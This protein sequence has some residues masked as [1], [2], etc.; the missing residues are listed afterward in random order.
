MK[1]AN[2]NSDSHPVTGR[3]GVAD[4]IKINIYGFAINTLWTPMSTILLPVLVLSF[5]DESVK[6]TQLALITLVGLVLAIIVQPVAGLV[7]DR[8]GCTWGKRRPYILVG[9]LFMIALLMSLGW[10]SSF[11]MLFLVICLLQIASNVANGPWFGFIPDLVPEDKRGI[12]SGVKGVIE[13]LGAIIGIQ[14]IGYLMSQRFPAGEETRLSLSLGVI[15]VTI[16]GAMLATMLTVKERPG[17]PGEKVNWLTIIFETFKISVKPHRDFIYYLISRLL[18]LV[19]LLMLRTFG[20]YLF[21]D[22]AQFADP[23]AV[24]ADLTIVLGICLLVAILPTGYLADRVGRR[25]ILIGSALVGIAGFVILFF[26]QTY[27]YVMIGG[28]LIGLAN[29]A[30]MSANWAMATDLV[31]KGEEAR[32]LGLTNLATGGA[33]IAATFAGPVIDFFNNLYT[34]KLGYQVVMAICIFLFVV[35]AI[36]IARVRTK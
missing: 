27:V 11:A 24:I 22:V 31:G 19:P 5:V 33:A 29:G 32:Y 14:L 2:R 20:L 18:F 4:Y 17:T 30:F 35:C 28:G 16:A 10:T 15:S 26:F 34:P 1:D 3:F 36:M 12:A 6:N 13:M 21:R 9:S 8:S 7:S 23:I 25:P